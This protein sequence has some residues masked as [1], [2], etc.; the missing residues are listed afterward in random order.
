M[1][2]SKGSTAQ[3]IMREFNKRSGESTP[4]VLELV[5]YSYQVGYGEG[6]D[7]AVKFYGEYFGV[8]ND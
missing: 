8:D 3:D 7:A 5:Q 1:P 4:A 6:Y 2:N